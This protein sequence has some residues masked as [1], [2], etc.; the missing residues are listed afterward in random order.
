MG[1]T[2][3]SDK[4]TGGG[5]ATANVWKW[6]KLSAFDGGEPPVTE[7]PVSA[8]N[9][10]Q[11]FQV[12]GREDGLGLDKF[13]FGVKGVYYTVYDLD[14]GLPGTTVPPPP[15]YLPPGPPLATDSPEFLGSVHST[16]QLVSLAAYFNQVT[17]ENAGKWDSV[18]H[19]RDVMTWSQLDAAYNFAKTNSFPFRMHTMVWGNQQ[20]PWIESL[21]PAEQLDEI[22]E[23]FSA[24]AV[25]YP[26]LD[27]V[28]VVN[29]PLHEHPRC[30]PGSRCSR[31]RR[32][33]PS[34]TRSRS[35]SWAKAPHRSAISGARTASRSPATP[36]P[37]RPP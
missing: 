34:R 9:L 3:P 24:V 37:R 25:R 6:V 5:V 17:P 22:K 8:S 28:E 12:A 14:N 33:R 1:F 35:R 31:S 23:W 20:P 2:L 30:G 27:F 29:E 26:D 16:S 10:T 7:F 15:P 36:R 13:A 21:P 4:V 18:E 19:T 11:V 32:R